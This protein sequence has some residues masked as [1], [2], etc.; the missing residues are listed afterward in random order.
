MCVP[1]QATADWNDGVLSRTWR[2]ALQAQS[3]DR[4]HAD[5]LSSVVTLNAVTRWL[6]SQ[7]QTGRPAAEHRGAGKLAPLT[8]AGMG[9][10]LVPAC[11]AWPFVLA[12]V[13]VRVR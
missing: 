11:T 7:P 10:W 9:A 13:P 4:T 2:K 5:A 3:A 12:C 8:G 1:T 6:S